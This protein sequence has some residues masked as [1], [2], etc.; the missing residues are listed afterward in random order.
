[1]VTVVGMMRMLGIVGR[2]GSV[3][4]FWIGVFGDDVPGVEEAREVAEGAEG[5]VDEGVGGA[6]TDFDPDCREGMLA[7][8]EGRGEGFE[9]LWEG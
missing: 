7:T 4:V 9:G 2:D 3:F 1:M 6:E 5:E 8:K